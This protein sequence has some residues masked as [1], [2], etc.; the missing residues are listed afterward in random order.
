MQR[1]WQTDFMSNRVNHNTCDR[2]VILSAVEK[3]RRDTDGCAAKF[4]DSARNDQIV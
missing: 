4:L 2:T 1:R 3:S